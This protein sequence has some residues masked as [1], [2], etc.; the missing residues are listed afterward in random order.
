MSQL[1]KAIQSK[2]GASPDGVYGAK[3][4]HAIAQELG[5]LRSPVERTSGE[6]GLV[7]TERSLNSVMEFECGGES[8]YNLRYS[9]PSWP[10]GASGV[11]VGVGYDLG[12]HTKSQ[13]VRDWELVVGRRIAEL[14]ATCAGVKG[15]RAKAYRDRIEKSVR[16]SFEG[17]WKVFVDTTVPRFAKLTAG[18]FPN[19]H[20]MHPVTQ[21]MMLSVVFNR[22]S[23]LKGYRRRH[24]VQMRNSVT[25]Q[26]VINAIDQMK[27]I[28]PRREGNHPGIRNRRDKEIKIITQRATDTSPT[29]KL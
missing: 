8:F 19:H 16:I 12:Y 26:G 28:W 11:T 25:D 15:S 18:T 29:I 1:L 13:I 4:E 6:V 10:Q 9:R 3:T 27:V 20:R 2:V 22:G 5:L 23:S 14:L 7:V 24:M 17:A 21:A